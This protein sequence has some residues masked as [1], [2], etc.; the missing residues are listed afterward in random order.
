MLTFA[1]FF[2][3]FKKIN[4]MVRGF[5]KAS[6]TIALQKTFDAWRDAAEGSKF[7]PSTR[8]DFTQEAMLTLLSLLNDMVEPRTWWLRKQDLEQT[9]WSRHE[10]GFGG[11]GAIDLTLVSA[12]QGS[13]LYNFVDF[14]H[15][16]RG[17]RELNEFQSSPGYLWLPRGR[18]RS[19]LRVVVS[20]STPRPSLNELLESV[21]GS[22]SLSDAIS[23]Q[24]RDEILRTFRPGFGKCQVQWGTSGNQGKLHSVDIVRM[25]SITSE[26]GC[27]DAEV[28]EDKDCQPKTKRQRWDHRS[29][30]GNVVWKVV[31]DGEDTVTTLN[32][33]SILT[34]VSA[35]TL[36]TETL[37][38][39]VFQRSD[40]IDSSIALHNEWSQSQLLHLLQRP[41]KFSVDN[42]VEEKF[43]K[44]FRYSFS[45]MRR[46]NM[47]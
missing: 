1:D 6:D 28:I 15:L 14:W 4:A 30:R 36:T 45:E 27:S 34:F 22:G 39:L 11:Y 9:L 31:K 20:A 7:H 10:R 25:P 24:Q 46:E 37:G 35:Y 18:D 40:G 32:S 47:H 33:W 42:E 44:Y 5:D 17:Q 2:A 3:Q 12:P 8:I 21:I 29:P 43:R 38:D 23:D 16:K 26:F 19:S 13:M 41:V